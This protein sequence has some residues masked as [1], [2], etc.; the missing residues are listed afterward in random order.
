MTDW[1]QVADE[2][3]L[4]IV[5]M[6]TAS[7]QINGRSVE[8]AHQRM[9]KLRDDIVRHNTSMTLP[10]IVIELPDKTRSEDEIAEIAAFIKEVRER[11]GLGL[12]DAK[13]LVDEYI[14]TLSR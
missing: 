2:L 7:A 9:E 12:K 1:K 8:D 13:D 11:T 6:A 5:G 3:Y 14:A 10:S 4:V